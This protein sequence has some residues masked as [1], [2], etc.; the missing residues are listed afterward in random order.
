MTDVM[1]EVLD[2]AA[3]NESQDAIAS[4]RYGPIV[5]IINP[6]TPH[7]DDEV[8]VTINHVDLL[9]PKVVIS[10]QPTNLPPGA[11]PFD[12]DVTGLGQSTKV[13][14]IL[15][16]DRF[17]F[18]VGDYS[19]TAGDDKG[20]PHLTRG[21][22]DARQVEF[23]VRRGERRVSFNIGMRALASNLDFYLDPKIENNG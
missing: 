18:T 7:H 11:T 3:E 13:R 2:A 8:T 22:G 5:R 1:N 21:S 20:H 23:Y 12:I 15:A 14:M 17:E 10:P 6:G 19:I 16:D 4:V 9:D